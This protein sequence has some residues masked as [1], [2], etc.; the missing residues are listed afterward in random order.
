MLVRHLIFI[1][2]KCKSRKEKHGWFIEKK[3]KALCLH[4]IIIISRSGQGCYIIIQ[5]CFFMLKRLYQKNP[6]HKKS[7]TKKSIQDTLFFHRWK[8]WLFS[9]TSGFFDK[10]T[11]R[12]FS[13]KLPEYFH[14][15][16]LSFSFTMIWGGKEKGVLIMQ[17]LHVVKSCNQLFR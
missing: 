4:S 10:N 6:W 15:I 2:I 12:K 11:W 3:R 13:T 17:F 9:L 5:M 16:S 8:H 1:L 14:P 7:I